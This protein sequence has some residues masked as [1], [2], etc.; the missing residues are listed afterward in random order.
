MQRPAVL[1]RPPPGFPALTP[2]HKRGSVPPSADIPSWAFLRSFTAPIAPPAERTPTW[3]FLERFGAPPPPSAD[4]SWADL[5][6]LLELCT[7][8][9]RHQLLA[10]EAERA[11]WTTRL[12]DL[13][14]DP[15]LHAWREFRPLRTSRE[16]DWS[17]WLQHLLATSA[18]GAFA[19]AL[20]SHHLGRRVPTFA[21]PAVLRELVVGCRRADLVIVWTGCG[22]RT[23]IEV[24]TGDQDFAKTFDTSRLL[25][26]HDQSTAWTH[27]ILLCPSDLGA[28]RAVAEQ[29]SPRFPEV[30]VV[31]LDWRQVVSAL[32][33]ALWSQAVENAAWRVWA[34][35]FVGV[36]EQRLLDLDQPAALSRATTIM[37]EARNGI[38]D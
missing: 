9:S 28:W 1:A 17:D 12:A 13:G 35:T 24:K 10:F 18:S 2:G 7:I 21:S 32:R 20:L 38:P 22:L 5:T 36:I 6:Q 11:L 30:H 31:A 29:E 25:M 8:A 4:A 15:S 3:A 16:E 14:G 37:K 34:W 27:C 19:Q 26:E 23:H 33:R